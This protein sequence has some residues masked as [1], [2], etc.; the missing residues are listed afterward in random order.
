MGTRE[1]EKTQNTQITIGVA[2]VYRVC[3][4]SPKPFSLFRGF[5]YEEEGVLTSRNV[6]KRRKLFR[7][8]VSLRRAKLCSGT[9]LIRREGFR[10]KAFQIRRG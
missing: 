5:G 2:A 8:E 3:D 7:K 6:A 9:V 1:T 10:R 4:F